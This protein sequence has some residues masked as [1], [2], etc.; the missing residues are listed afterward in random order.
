[1]EKLVKVLKR[2]TSG[3]KV[4]GLMTPSIEIID[5]LFDILN[6]FRTV[7]IYRE[8]TFVLK[9]CGIPYR[10]VGMFFIVET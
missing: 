5:E 4:K 2:W 1:M 7:T 9:Y 8:V 3:K 10:E 6:G